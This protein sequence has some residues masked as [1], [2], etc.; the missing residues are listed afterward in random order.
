MENQKENQEKDKFGNVTF[1]EA[2]RLLI[3]IIGQNVILESMPEEEREAF[4]RS[5]ERMYKGKANYSKFAVA[6]PESPQWYVTQFFEKI[7]EERYEL[8]RLAMIIVD[9]F[10][11][12][13]FYAL[14]T[15]TFEKPKKET[16]L[17]LIRKELFNLIYHSLVKG[18]SLSD[19]SVFKIPGDSIITFLTDSYDKIFKDIESLFKN[20]KIFYEEINN[21]CRDNYKKYPKLSKNDVKIDYK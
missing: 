1:G 9:S 14:C 15:T 4:K 8:S 13:L 6:E 12:Q 2:S 19:G 17:Y 16:A 3:D 11:W 5:L 21:Y 18:E 20:E 7:L 10:T